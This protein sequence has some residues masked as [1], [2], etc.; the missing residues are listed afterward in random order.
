MKILLD[1]LPLVLFFL[2]YKTHGIYVATAVLMVATVAQMAYIYKTEGGLQGMHKLT[3]V[4]ILIFGGFTL[5]LQDERFIK[6]KPTVLY[7]VIALVLLLARQIWQK[8]LI[9]LLLSKQIPLSDSVWDKLNL[10][11]VCYAV[12]M[13]LLNAYVVMYYSTSDWMSFKLWGFAFPLV[14]LIGQAVYISRHMQS[15]PGSD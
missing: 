9:H 12:F 8:N 1:F 4:L 6:W 3:L 7:A 14:F 10:S 13:A 11:W 15:N 5:L 2:A